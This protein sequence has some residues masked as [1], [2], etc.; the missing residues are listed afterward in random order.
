MRQDD[1]A[2][3]FRNR[4]G[5]VLC[6]HR[7]AVALVNAVERRQGATRMRSIVWCSLRAGE[8]RCTEDCGTPRRAPGAKSA[9]GSTPA[10]DSA[11]E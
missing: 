2:D 4:S 11:L 9:I 6:P 1:S 3:T 8:Q 10:R 5:F 7:G